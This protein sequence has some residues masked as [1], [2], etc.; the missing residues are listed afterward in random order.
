M[1]VERSVTWR[2]LL[3]SCLRELDELDI[4]WQSA[5]WWERQ[6]MAYT[7]DGLYR[8]IDVALA[9]IDEHD[10]DTFTGEY[11]ETPW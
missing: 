4:A 9:H 1:V 2:Q 7:R 3:A 5:T 11:E 8:D 6:D 10:F